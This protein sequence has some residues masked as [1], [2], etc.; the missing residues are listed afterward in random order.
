MVSK[1]IIFIGYLWRRKPEYWGK[2]HA[3]TCHNSLKK[4]HLKWFPVHLAIGGTKTHNLL[5]IVTD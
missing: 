4:Y 1:M 3:L 2:P 5:V